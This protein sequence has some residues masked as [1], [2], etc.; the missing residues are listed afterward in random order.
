MGRYQLI[1]SFRAAT[2]FTPHAY[3]LNARINRARQWRC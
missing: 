1:R 3:L 2:G